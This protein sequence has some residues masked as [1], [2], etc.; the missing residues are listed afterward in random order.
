MR[1]RGFFSFQYAKRQAEEQKRCHLHLRFGVNFA[2]QWPQSVSSIC[3]SVATIIICPMPKECVA[4]AICVSRAPCGVG[5]LPETVE[6]FRC[7][8]F[9]AP[10][11]RIH[12]LL[13]FSARFT[14]FVISFRVAS[15]EITEQNAGSLSCVLPAT[16]K[17]RSNPWAGPESHNR[18][19]RR[20]RLA[21]RCCVP[22]RLC[23]FCAR[24][25]S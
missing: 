9:D 14:S 22:K 18:K 20:K 2:A 21:R 8:P 1:S 10:A 7:I 4:T 5:L 11:E 16:A 19:P 25:S 15:Q 12:N 23:S 17:A 13:R 24:Y 6:D 3:D